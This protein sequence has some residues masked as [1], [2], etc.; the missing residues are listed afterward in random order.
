MHLEVPADIE[1]LINKRLV[2]GAYE[3]I[4]DVLRQALEARDAEGSWTEEER[5]ALM[6]HI[7]EGYRQAERGELIDGALARAIREMKKDW[8]HSRR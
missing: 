8:R 5:N 6:A 2:S 3:V 7:A 1:A 4:E